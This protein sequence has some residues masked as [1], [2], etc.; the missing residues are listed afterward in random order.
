MSKSFN[1]VFFGVFSRSKGITIWCHLF[2]HWL[3]RLEYRPSTCTEYSAT[4]I[5]IHYLYYSRLLNVSEITMSIFHEFPLMLCELYMK[6]DKKLYVTNYTA[7]IFRSTEIYWKLIVAKS[8]LILRFEIK[9]LFLAYSNG[10]QMVLV[11][12]NKITEE[13]TSERHLQCVFSFVILSYHIMNIMQWFMK[14]FMKFSEIYLSTHKKFFYYSS[15]FPI[16]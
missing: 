9:L 7:H 14:N 13:S 2:E 10:T 5:F 12:G 1:Y 6:S 8:T 16:I 11:A 15:I 3:V 4:N